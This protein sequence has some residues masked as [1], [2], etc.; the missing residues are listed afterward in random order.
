MPW[1]SII[2]PRRFGLYRPGE[3]EQG[4]SG[5]GGGHGQEAAEAGTEVQIVMDQTPFYAE[6]G[7]QIGDRGYLS[8]DNVVI[9]VEDVKKES[10]FF[11]HIRSGGT[12][13]RA[14]GRSRHGAD[15]SGL[16]APGHGQPHRHP[17]AAGGTEKIVD[18]SISQAG[19]LVA[20]DRLRFDFNC[21]RALTAEEVQQVEEQVNT[22]I[23]EG[24]GADVE[25]MPI[26]EAKKR[27]ARSLCLAKSTAPRCG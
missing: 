15:R 25:E 3:H 14:G 8:G 19:S 21:P 5:F 7:G 17:S 10:D 26:E 18:D 23:A 4:G 12:G 6:S 13:H 16:S 1:R 9:R 27:R 22:W 2:Q 20:F 11:L 24:H